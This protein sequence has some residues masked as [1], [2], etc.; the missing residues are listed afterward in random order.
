MALSLV[1]LGVESLSIYRIVSHPTTYS[2]FLEEIGYDRSIIDN[3]IPV[4]LFTAVEQPSAQV[5][6][7][8]F[9]SFGPEARR[10]PKNGS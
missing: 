2:E 6:F 8:A 10:R 7:G 5:I 3:P 9:M 4:K 1:A